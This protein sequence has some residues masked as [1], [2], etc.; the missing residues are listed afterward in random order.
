VGNAHFLNGSIQCISML[1][2]FSW[3][4]LHLDKLG[5]RFMAE[6]IIGTDEKI[7]FTP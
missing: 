1:I 5:C 6:N 3:C 4:G 7:D 2:S